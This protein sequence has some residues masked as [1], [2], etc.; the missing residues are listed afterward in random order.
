MARIFPINNELAASISVS[1]HA[2][3]DR[4]ETLPAIYRPVDF[5]SPSTIG[6][7]VNN[8]GIIGSHD[9]AIYKPTSGEINHSCPVCT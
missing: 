3:G 4:L 6:E 2:G 9:Y 1:A 8:I 7:D 5:I